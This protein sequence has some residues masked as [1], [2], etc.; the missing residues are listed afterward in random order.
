MDFF[1]FGDDTHHVAI[2]AQAKKSLLFHH[3]FIP[4]GITSSLLNLLN[5]IDPEEYDVTV[6]VPVDDT[7]AHPERVE[8]FEKIPP[9]VRVIGRVG[10]QL[11]TPEEKWVVDRLNKHRTLANDS[12]MKIYRRTFASG[13]HANIWTAQI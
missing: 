3:S 4:N 5:L 11:F 7:A 9:Y 10:R 12:Q 2:R 13:I 8:Q 1:F 6:V